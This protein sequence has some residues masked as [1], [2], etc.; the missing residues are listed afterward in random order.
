MARGS[1][2]RI[3]KRIRKPPG[4]GGCPGANVPSQFRR[5]P[6]REGKRADD[7]LILE[8]GRVLE[9]GPR[10][11]LANDPASNYS[12]LLRTGLADVLA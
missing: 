11:E 6:L 10:A 8:N 5:R 4:K 2:E 9:K 3:G 7:I 1:D 12:G